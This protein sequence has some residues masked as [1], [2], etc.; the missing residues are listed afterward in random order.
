[1]FW[2]LLG[3]FSV[4]QAGMIRSESISK[5]SSGMLCQLVDVGRV[6]LANIKYCDCLIN[7]YGKYICENGEDAE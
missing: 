1:M 3:N 5:G 6:E 7:S 4:E 2:Q